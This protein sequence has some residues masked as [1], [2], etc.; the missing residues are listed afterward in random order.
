MTP[1]VKGL[2]I[3][4]AHIALVASLGGKLLYDRAMRPRIWVRAAPYDP[5]LPIRG[6]YVS[7][8]LVVEP[9]G[10]R[11]QKSGDQWPAPQS[12][13]LRSDQ[14]R[15]V[16]EVIPNTGYEASDVHVL[17]VQRRGEKLAVLDQPCAF[18]IPEHI[19]DPSVR[20][21]GEQLWVEVTIPRKG[22]P[23]P[24]Q[25]GVKKNNASIVPLNI[26]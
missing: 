10:L 15:L 11:E 4:V 1:L 13:T 2:A 26:D 20:P 22:P 5:T 9:R 14:D 16:A 18:Y 17:Y 19:A 6:R 3:A 7:L 8:Q 21:E 24:I 12:V 25:L 23:R